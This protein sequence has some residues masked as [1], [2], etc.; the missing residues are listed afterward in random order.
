M[1]CMQRSEC[2][3]AMQRAAAVLENV[4][5]GSR[6]MRRWGKHTGFA[7]LHT[8][9]L[10]DSAQS[11]QERMRE[12]T[13]CASARMARAWWCAVRKECAQKGQSHAQPRTWRNWGVGG[14]ISGAT[15]SVAAL[16][17]EYPVFV[18]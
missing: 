5:R 14:H 6:W 9:R 7:A 3:V 17:F 13:D 8:T 15:T 4:G 2:V 10:H 16:T 11:V 18:L 12:V 1:K